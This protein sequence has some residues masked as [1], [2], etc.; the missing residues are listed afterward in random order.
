MKNLLF[1]MAV[2]PCTKLQEPLKFIGYILLMVKIIIP[3]I[4]IVFGIIDLFKAITGGKDGEVAKSLKTFVFR[5]IAGVA[6]FFVPTII[7]F[8]FSLVDSFDDVQSEF[9][10]CQKCILN[11]SQCKKEE[12]VVNPEVVKPSVTGDNGDPAQRTPAVQ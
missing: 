9:D 4:L 3:L 11:V 8:V 1:I 10:L 2:S 12:E 6:I 5:M 7:S